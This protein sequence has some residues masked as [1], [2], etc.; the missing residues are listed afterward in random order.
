[1]HQT[2]QLYSYIVSMFTH[3]QQKHNRKTQKDTSVMLP[4]LKSDEVGQVRHV[5]GKD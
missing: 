4:A 5:V 1:M 2:L 3:T